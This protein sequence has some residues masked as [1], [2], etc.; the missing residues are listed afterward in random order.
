MPQIH[1]DE[2]EDAYEELLEN[3]MFRN[4]EGIPLSGSDADI[5][6]GDDGEEY[7]YYAKLLGYKTVPFNSAKN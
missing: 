6:P 7:E 5:S 3:G 4:R 1:S 2:D